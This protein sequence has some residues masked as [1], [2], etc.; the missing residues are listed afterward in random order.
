M[1]FIYLIIF[2]KNVMIQLI[3]V[4]GNVEFVLMMYL[5]IILVHV[6]VIHIIHKVVI[7][8]VLVVLKIVLIVN[9]MWKNKKQNV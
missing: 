1:D 2:V 4:M 7:Q 8:V 9:I 3:L 5:I 6:G